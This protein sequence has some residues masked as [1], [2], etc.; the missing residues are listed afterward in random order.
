MADLKNITLFLLD[1][2]GTVNLGY[3]PIDGAKE[4]LETLKEQGKNY[5]F[6]TNNSSK[7]ASDYVEKMRSLGFPCESE[8]VFTSGMAA[9][10]FLEE[11][12]KGS[13]VYVCGT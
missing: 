1:M 5:I 7:S 12:K 6:L 10:M 2:D 3:D 11:N 9:G 4:F 8:N 13:K